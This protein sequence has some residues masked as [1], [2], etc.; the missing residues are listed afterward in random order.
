MNPARDLGLRFSYEVFIRPKK[1]FENL[2]IDS[3]G[4]KGSA[5]WWSLTSCIILHLLHSRT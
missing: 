4:Q 5:E 1:G 2:F 3:K